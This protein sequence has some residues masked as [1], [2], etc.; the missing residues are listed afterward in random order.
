MAEVVSWRIAHHFVDGV[1]SSLGCPK[2]GR[3]TVSM[4]LANAVDDLLRRRGFDHAPVG[5]SNDVLWCLGGPDLYRDTCDM[6]ER[7]LLDDLCVD[8]ELKVCDRHKTITL[9]LYPYD[10]VPE[11]G[12]SGPGD[13]LR[14]S[15]IGLV[16]LDDD[17]V[18]ADVIAR[19]EVW[20]DS[21]IVLPR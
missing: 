15:P 1:C 12:G 3:S 11:S 13:Q 10:L 18:V 5:E 19:A 2:S 14:S 6:D 20:L 17:G 16:G 4:T 9:R 21:I 8:L 7:P